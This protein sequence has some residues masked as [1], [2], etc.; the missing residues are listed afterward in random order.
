[1]P[2]EKTTTRKAAAKGKADGGKK[3]KGEPNLVGVSLTL[4]T[5]HQIQTCQS[6]VFQPTCSLPTSSAIRFATTIQA[7]S[8]VS[9]FAILQ[10]IS[11]LT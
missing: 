4:L 10:L 8:L 1:M 2:K 6:A 11:V 7:S 3:K 9:S 5:R